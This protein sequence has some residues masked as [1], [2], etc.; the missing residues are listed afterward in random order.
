MHY[1][2]ADKF[3]NGYIHL[4]NK[5]IKFSFIVKVFNICL[6]E[7]CIGISVVATRRVIRLVYIHEIK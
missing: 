5:T 7:V 1:A 3:M 2:D 6:I 4:N